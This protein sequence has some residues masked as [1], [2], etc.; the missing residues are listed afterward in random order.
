MS[1]II[2]FADG[3]ENSYSVYAVESET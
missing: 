1:V 3:N 2:L